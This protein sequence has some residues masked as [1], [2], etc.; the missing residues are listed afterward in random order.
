MSNWAQRGWL[1]ARE[2]LTGEPARG[3]ALRL[4]PLFASLL[5]CILTTASS[6]LCIFSGSILHMDL[7]A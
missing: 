3:S 4:T 6:L 5:N 7:A 2:V 1:Q